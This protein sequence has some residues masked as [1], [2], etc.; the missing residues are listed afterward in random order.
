VHCVRGGQ[1]PRNQQH[2]GVGES[3]HGRFLLPLHDGGHVAGAMPCGLLLPRWLGAAHAVHHGLLLRAERW[4]S[5]CVPRGLL[6]QRRRGRVY[7]IHFGHNA[8]HHLH[9]HRLAQCGEHDCWDE[10]H[11]RHVH[12][13]HR[14]QP[15]HHG[16]VHS[17]RERFTIGVATSHCGRGEGVPS[18]L[19]QHGLRGRLHGLR[20]GPL[21]ER[22]GHQR[23]SDLQPVHSGLLLPVALNCEHCAAAVPHPL[24]L[25]RG[26]H[27]AHGMHV[28]IGPVH[29]HRR[30]ASR[31]RRSRVPRGLLLPRKRDCAVALPRGLLRRGTEPQ[32]DNVHAAVPRGH[33]LPRG[34][35]HGGVH[36]CHIWDRADHHRHG[37]GL[38]LR[39]HGHHWRGRDTG[40]YHPHALHESLHLHVHG[41]G[42][43]IAN[44]DVH[45]AHGRRP[46]VPARL[47]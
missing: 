25:R 8:V 31:V 29:Y 33:V 26:R 30:A 9:D 5:C 40:H 14:A 3:V 15:L 36:R 44:G 22:L 4:R 45:G 34:H 16:H 1:L 46:R 18:G 20:G 37:V 35:R 19:P 21:L 7:G 17:H 28:P 41:D 13:V 42:E 39:G 12:C 24:F 11:C 6:L 27:R 23:C 43:C 38:P 32:C 47:F 2:F 10:R